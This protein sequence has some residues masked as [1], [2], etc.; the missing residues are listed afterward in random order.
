[1]DK[2]SII[3][4]SAL[5]AMLTAPLF[6]QSSASCPAHHDAV[7]ARG[8]HVMGFDHDKTTHHFLLTTTGGIIEVT[9]NSDGDTASRDAIR[10]HLQHIAMMFADG[11]YEAPMLVHDRVPPGVPVMKEKKKVIAWTYSEIANGGEVVATTSDGDALA[12]I[13][14]FLRFQIDDHQ[15]GDSTEVSNPGH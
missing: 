8:D 1:M 4:A 6:A 10:G 3:G 11:D 9:A 13:H 14:E 5:S 2:L 7:N 12:A 15:T